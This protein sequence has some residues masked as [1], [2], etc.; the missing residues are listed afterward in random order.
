MD[1]KESGSGQGKTLDCGSDREALLYREGVEGRS[2][3]VGDVSWA[4]RA[5]NGGLETIVSGGEE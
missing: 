3:R 2:R 4:S 5:S 1:P